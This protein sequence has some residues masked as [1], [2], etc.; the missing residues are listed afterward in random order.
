M[1]ALLLT[2]LPVAVTVVFAIVAL[3]R[4]RIERRARERLENKLQ[5]METVLKSARQRHDSLAKQFNEL[6]AGSMGMGQKLADIA[7]NV[8]E[9]LE[10]QVELEMQDP[11]SR[12]YSRASKMVDLGADL[13]ELM[14]ECDLPKAEAELLLSLRKRQAANQQR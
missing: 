3:W 6:R 8:D 13:D 2:W 1:V 7:T 11:G 9:L 12:L 4:L 10:K 5:A 14:H